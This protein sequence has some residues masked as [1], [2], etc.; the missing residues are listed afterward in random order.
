MQLFDYFNPEL[1]AFALRQLAAYKFRTFLTVLGIIIGI[2]SVVLVATVL[3]GIRANVVT[4]FQEL[5]PNNIFVF[6]LQGDP[7]NPTVKPEEAT[8]KP[9]P[10]DYASRLEENCP[11]VKGVAVQI[12]MAGVVGGRPITARYR[13]LENDRILSQGVS[14]NFTS[15]T[16]AET[17]LGRTFTQE[18]ERRRARVCV[19]GPN[20]EASLFANEN[21]LGKRIEIDSA[22]YQVIG[23]LDKRKGSF[24]GE[25]RQ[26]NTILIP[27]ATVRGRYPEADQVVLYCQSRPNL[28][29]S[30]LWEIETELRRL[31]GLRADEANDF[32][33]STVDLIIRQLD[34]VTAMIR[35]ATLTVSG[36]GLLIG[37][38]GV[39]NIM[40][41]SVTQRTREIGIRKA[42]GAR[43]KD[44]LIQF[45]LEAGLLTGLGGISGVTLSLF[46]GLAI[47]ILVPNMP[48]VPPFWAIAMGLGMSVSVGMVF[49]IWPAMKAASLDPVESLRYE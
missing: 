47:H 9:L 41:M 14:W 22:L 1:P 37:G 39:M 18:E 36:L 8:R 30:A 28:R 7:Y 6:H 20:V 2:V 49:G 29:E 44:I 10:V 43:R 24:F 21:P 15:I 4:L 33:M 45:L 12:M 38:I 23:V 32:I 17:S 3:V 42:I 31:R 19:I 46:L 40:L 5:G 27:A 35:L 26:D 11:S 25:N 48:A 34:R 16:A 13:G